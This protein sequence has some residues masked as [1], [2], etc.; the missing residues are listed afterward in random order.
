MVLTDN[1]DLETFFIVLPLS[2][3]VI[4]A[5]DPGEGSHKRVTTDKGEVK[6]CSRSEGM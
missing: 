1:F 6:G 5:L 4:V 3:S 2:R